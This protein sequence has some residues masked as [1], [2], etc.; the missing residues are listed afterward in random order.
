MQYVTLAWILNRG[1]KMLERT[2]SIGTTDNMGTQTDFV[3]KKP[4]CVHVK[5]PDFNNCTVVTL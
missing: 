5:F 2:D 4:H 3:K 1:R